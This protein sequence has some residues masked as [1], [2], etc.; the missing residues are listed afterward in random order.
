MDA[1]VAPRKVSGDKARWD[2]DVQIDSDQRSDLKMGKIASDNSMSSRS[3][4]SELDR[5]VE[6]DHAE[7]G[8]K[9]SAPMNSQKLDAEDL[10]AN[11]NTRP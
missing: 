5:Q 11:I 2:V 10:E 8:S 9:V 7:G 3:R 4:D 1:I 6:E